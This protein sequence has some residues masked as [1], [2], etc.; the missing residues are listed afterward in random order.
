MATDILLNTDDL[1][2]VHG[3][4]DCGFADE[5]HIDLLLRASKGDFKEHPLLGVGIYQYINSS[6]DKASR[7]ALQREV[8]LQLE[9]DGCKVN[10]ISFDS[11]FNLVIDGEY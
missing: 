9:V 10:S 7:M 4:F 2:I 1:N 6:Q 11:D 5:Q 8:G 3:D